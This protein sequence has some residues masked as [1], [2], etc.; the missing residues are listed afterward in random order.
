MVENKYTALHGDFE[1]FN[2]LHL[3]RKYKQFRI[4][5]KAVLHLRLRFP[6]LDIGSH[7]RLDCQKTT[8]FQVDCQA[9]GD[10]AVEPCPAF[11]RI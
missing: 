10:S 7:R 5:A 9:N 2:S 3:R 4:V 1:N 8:Q 6:Q 11:I